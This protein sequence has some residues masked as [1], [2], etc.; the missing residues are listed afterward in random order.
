MFVKFNAAENDIEGH[1]IE[2]LP[3]FKFYRAGKKN[4]PLDFDGER[5][6]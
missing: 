2:T 3:I 6:K 4:E 1:F 5:N